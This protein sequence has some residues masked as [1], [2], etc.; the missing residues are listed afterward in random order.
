MGFLQD[1][2]RRV[3]GVALVLSL[4]SAG[5]VAALF[6]AAGSAPSGAPAAAGGPPPPDPVDA[7]PAPATAV[8]LVAAGD[9]SRVAGS[10]VPVF[11]A[12]PRR[13]ARYELTVRRPGPVV[14]RYLPA[15]VPA[16]ERG[17]GRLTVAT[18]PQRGAYARVRAEAARPGQR[19]RRL[20]GGGV[21]VAGAGATT[22]A[23]LAFPRVD[24]QVEVYDPRPG[25]AWALA[26]AGRIRPAP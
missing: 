18:Y 15:G 6:A 4:T 7:A 10:G 22:S 12:G 8:R 1:P 19:S 25:A 23:F 17:V 3:R 16:G 24:V 14:L 5:A 20:P 11:W 13:G 2:V 9:L 21:A 26:A